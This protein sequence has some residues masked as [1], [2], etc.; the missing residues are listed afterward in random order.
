MP[1]LVNFNPL[2]QTYKPGQ[3]NDRIE[4]GY[5]EA[6][7]HI[8][9][10]IDKAGER[11]RAREKG[12]ESMFD[13]DISKVSDMESKKYIINKYRSLKDDYI[14]KFQSNRNWM[15]Y[16][17]LPPEERIELRGNLD[18][19]TSEAEML[20]QLDQASVAADKAVSGNSFMIV[21]EDLRNQYSAAK[22]SGNV[23]DMAEVVSKI[24][25][26]E[27]NTPFVKYAEVNPDAFI[28][29]YTKS[30]QGEMDKHET[31][32]KTEYEKNGKLYTAQ[33]ISA[34][35]GSENEARGALYSIISKGEGGPVIETNLRKQLSPQ[36]AEYIEANYQGETFPYLKYYVD[37][38]ADVMPMVE[39]GTKTVRSSEPIKEPASSKSKGMRLRFGN[40]EGDF[41]SERTDFTV[42][43]KKYT[44]MFTF[45]EY[46]TKERIDAVKGARNIMGGE[47]GEAKDIT[48][49]GRL[50]GYD[51][52]E[53]VIVIQDKYGDYYEAD[54]DNNEVVLKNLIHPDDY[55]KL[56]EYQKV[57][58]KAKTKKKFEEAI[59][60]IDAKVAEDDYSASQEAGINAFMKANGLSRK[61]AVQILKDNNKL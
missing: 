61:D 17:K 30:V 21:D 50:V 26:S 38:K 56:L 49:V 1:S 33:D 47:A 6:G 58:P 37:F 60:D 13:V 51:V 15:G 34:R 18:A 5:K 44:D 14:Q 52:E 9:N 4:R 3:H 54:R 39:G 16:G 10:A 35:Y 28:K 45:P 7:Q 20:K 8:A 31:A 59:A 27:A 24:G 40:E 11:G 42:E 12:F 2:L 25:Q 19:L 29:N 46:K 57:S 55:Q 53:D 22:K 48:D 43:G 32:T 41:D 23:E 36:E